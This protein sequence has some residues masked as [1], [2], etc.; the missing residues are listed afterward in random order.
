[1]FF[2]WRRY[3]SVVCFWSLSVNMD[4]FKNRI[5]APAVEDILSCWKRRG[6]TAWKPNR[7]T[8]PFVCRSNCKEAV[9]AA[10][11]R[12]ACCLF[13]L[14]SQQIWTKS[15]ISGLKFYFAWFHSPTRSELKAI[16]W[17]YCSTNRAHFLLT[18]YIRFFF[19]FLLWADAQVSLSH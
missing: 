8:N 3:L 9:A 16:K 15:L 18:V 1:M 10:A 19:P 6:K 7:K 2:P 11:R 17:R 13:V 14:H 5:N 12:S 4:W